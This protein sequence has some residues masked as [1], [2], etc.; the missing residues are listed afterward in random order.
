MISFVCQE[1]ESVNMVLVLFDEKG[2][3]QTRWKSK[4]SSRQDDGS[5]TLGEAMHF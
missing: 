1:N 2:A 4:E 3:E 5:M